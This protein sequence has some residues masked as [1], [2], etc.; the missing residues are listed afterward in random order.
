MATVSLFLFRFLCF[1]SGDRKLTYYY[2]LS[3]FPSSLS[4]VSKC[5]HRHQH[6]CTAKPPLHVNTF[7]IPFVNIDVSPISSRTHSH[8]SHSQTS[9]HSP[10]QH[11][12]RV[13]YQYDDVPLIFEP[14]QNEDAR[15]A[16]AAPHFV[17]V[18]L[19]CCFTGPY[20]CK[21]RKITSHQRNSERFFLCTL[22]SPQLSLSLSRKF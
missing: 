10:S 18:G 13:G 19:S 4:N 22:L 11:R 17:W 15:K 5:Q 16:D 8:P 14:S 2:H 6:M 12:P 7:V 3:V 20:P 21:A 9:T 1:C